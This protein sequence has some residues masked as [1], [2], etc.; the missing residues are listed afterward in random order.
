MRNIVSQLTQ[1]LAILVQNRDRNVNFSHKKVMQRAMYGI[2]GFNGFN[3]VILR[4]EGRGK[5]LCRR[6]GEVGVVAAGEP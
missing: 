5:K 6:E 3:G 1:K 4:R 2:N